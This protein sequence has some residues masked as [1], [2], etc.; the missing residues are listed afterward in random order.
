MKEETT[1]INGIRVTKVI[2]EPMDTFNFYAEAKKSRERIEASQ[3]TGK[4]LSKKKKEEILR[5][6]E[7]QFGSK[8]IISAI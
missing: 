4:K 2:S 5:K 1:Y 7:E 8:N 3:K 6:F